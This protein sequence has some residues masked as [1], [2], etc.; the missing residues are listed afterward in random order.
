MFKNGNSQKSFTLAEVLITLGIIGIVAAMTLPSIIN[1]TRNKE[2]ETRLKI[3]YSL[4]TNAVAYLHSQDIQI[5]G[6]NFSTA[7]TASATTSLASVLA[8]AFNHVGKRTTSGSGFSVPILNGQ[9][10][11]HLYKTM[12]GASLSSGLLDDG[13]FELNN[14]MS[15]FLETNTSS[16]FPI[17]FFDFNGVMGKP[18]RLGYDMFAF[19]IDKNDKVCPAGSPECESRPELL[20]Y[21]KF[22]SK[23]SAPYDY[24]DASGIT[25][26]YK[27]I[28]DKDYF[29][30][31]K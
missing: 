23:T 17:I 29:K 19:I 9:A 7:N 1:T 18:N 8:N 24:G 27:A 16:N 11:H 13:Y 6:S 25:C 30:N 4:L 14:G 2:N 20:D 3:A 21:E 12:S 10:V 31:L 28:I 5:Y 15:I 22:C 26:A